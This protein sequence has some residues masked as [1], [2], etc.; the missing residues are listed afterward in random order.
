MG[1]SIPVLLGSS[2]PSAALQTRSACSIRCVST[3]GSQIPRSNR[4][5]T[6]PTC[7]RLAPGEPP[8]SVCWRTRCGTPR[9][10][11]AALPQE[12]GVDVKLAI[13]FVLGAIDGEYDVGVVFSTDTDLR[14]ALEM[15]A[16]RFA[17]H[18]KPELAAWSSD[19]SR[20]RIPTRANRQLWC[21]YS[22]LGR[23]HDRLGPDQLGRGEIAPD[24]S[25]SKDATS[26]GWSAARVVLPLG[27]RAEQF[28]TAR[29]T[30]HRQQDSPSW[31]HAGLGVLWRTRAKLGHCA[32]R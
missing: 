12:K 2:S 20:R 22:E 25:R 11:P 17:A 28:L 23:L 7:A 29:V 24:S 30:A 13:D 3:R 27:Q 16:N 15:V 6:E 4:R 10:F 21:H 14:P 8:A 1:N 19:V 26:A 5:P 9:N 18:P 31:E 32:A